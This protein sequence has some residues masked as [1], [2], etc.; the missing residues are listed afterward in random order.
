[1]FVR[2]MM[3]SNM[4]CPVLDNT[5]A[6]KLDLCKPPCPSHPSYHSLLLCWP[7]WAPS[8]V[9]IGLCSILIPAP[10]GSEENKSSAPSDLIKREFESVFKRESVFQNIVIQLWNAVS[11]LWHSCVAVAI[12]YVNT[13]TTYCI[14]HL[15]YKLHTSDCR[16]LCL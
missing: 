15:G 1:M 4:S 9:L 13:S 12:L 10:V 16:E 8:F 7:G 11:S 14:K 2:E 6:E 5:G 3:H